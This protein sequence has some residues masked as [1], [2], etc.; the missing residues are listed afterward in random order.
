MRQIAT[1][2]DERRAQKLADYLLTLRIATRLEQA[3]DGWELWVCDED[4]VPQ[5]RQ[6]L[7]AFERN[8]D[9]SRYDGA[10]AVAENIR[11][12]EAH[13][14]KKYRKN[15]IDVRERWGDPSPANY[16]L[17]LALIALSVLASVLTGFGDN[18]GPVYDA[19]TITRYRV[20]HN[21]IVWYPGLPEVREGQVW[22]LVTPIFLHFN[23]SAFFGLSLHL[24]FN[25]FWL[26]DL[27]RQIEFRRGTWRLAVM[28]LVIAVASNLAQYLAVSPAFGGMSGV[29][30]G[31]FG[32]VWMKGRYD[33]D[34]GL[35]M[36]PTNVLLMMLWLVACS[37]GLVGNI[38]NW[39]HGVG[40]VTGVVM[41]V[42]S[43]KW[44]ELRR[45]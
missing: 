39:A 29:V 17:T 16:P 8:P 20:E 36:H 40:L 43:A 30:F 13:E 24:L 2:P 4:R 41:G 22:R 9:D 31:L 42:A 12:R 44:Q 19:L 34:S 11:R 45:R 18:K 33:P 3:A 21:L 32:Y 27:G 25:M 26:Y 15:F 1:L 10:V 38:A 28:V 5:A 7:E 6:E 35:T 23:S 14:E 37:T